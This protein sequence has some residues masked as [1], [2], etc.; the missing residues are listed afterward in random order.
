MGQVPNSSEKM[1]HTLIEKRFFPRRPISLYRQATFSATNV[2]FAF[3][4]MNGD[5]MDVHLR[6]YIFACEQLKLSV[7]DIF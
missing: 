7:C 1:L 6:K 3:I 4:V 5:T 2:T